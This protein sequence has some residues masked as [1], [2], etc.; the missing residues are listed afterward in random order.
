ML[1]RSQSV[2][3]SAFV[4]QKRRGAK[5]INKTKYPYPP[6]QESALGQCAAKLSNLSF[7]F[8]KFSYDFFNWQQEHLHKYG[9][10]ALS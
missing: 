6:H 2:A 8:Q 1:D 4:E 9:S 5:V 10:A 3:Y 7:Y